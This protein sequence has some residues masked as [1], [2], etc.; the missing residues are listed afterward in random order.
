MSSP[1]QSWILADSQTFTGEWMVVGQ[2]FSPRSLTVDKE[3]AQTS[4]EAERRDV[5]GPKDCPHVCKMIS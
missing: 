3:T 5:L 4:L 2:V 1:H